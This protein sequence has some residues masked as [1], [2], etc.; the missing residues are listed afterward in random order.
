MKTALHLWAAVATLATVSG[1]AAG[2]GASTIIV[3]YTGVVKSGVDNTGVFGPSGALLTGDTYTMVYTISDQAPGATRV[4]EPTFSW[5]FGS[6]TVTAVLTLDGHV[7]TND[8]SVFNDTVRQSNAYGSGYGF[9]Q[10]MVYD[11]SAGAEGTLYST[12][13]CDG[14]YSYVDMFSA[15]SYYGSSLTH[16]FVAGQDTSSGGFVVYDYG[17]TNIAAIAFTDDLSV[18]ITDPPSPGVPE[19]AG[20]ALMLAGFAGLGARLRAGRATNAT[21]GAAA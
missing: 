21:R 18:T 5:V 10:P 7:V 11:Y 14:I 2:A 19:P 9:N 16:D 1:V 3:T 12:L 13:F 8:G 4:N 17:T 20:W 15:S 6:G